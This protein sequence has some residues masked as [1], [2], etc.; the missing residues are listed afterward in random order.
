MTQLKLILIIQKGGYDKK[1]EILK[2]SHLRGLRQLRFL[3]FI[4]LNDN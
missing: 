2:Q 4:I 3:Y 1:G